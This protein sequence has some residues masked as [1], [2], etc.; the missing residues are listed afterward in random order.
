MTL[1]A[2]GTKVS[3]AAGKVGDVLRKAG[4]NV[5]SPA[6]ANGSVSSSSV[7][8]SSGFAAAAAAVAHLLGLPASAAR[9]EPAHPPVPNLQG[10]DVVVVVG[11]GL[12][13]HPPSGSG[14]STSGS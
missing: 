9:A 13:S 3:G 6:N 5:L 11:Q 7:Y 8:Y 14:S 10:A 4:Y 2:N 12:A 1:V